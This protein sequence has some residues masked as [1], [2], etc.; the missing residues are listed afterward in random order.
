MNRSSTR[1]APTLIVG[2][3]GSGVEIAQRVKNMML[4]GTERAGTDVPAHFL[5]IDLDAHSGGK[6]L[7]SDEFLYV[8]PA[9]VIDKLKHGDPQTLGWLPAMSPIRQ[10]H[11]QASGAA[12]HRGIGHL[13]SAVSSF[14]IESAL[15][16]A[17]SRLPSDIAR[18]FVIA[19]LAGGTGS[20][21]LFDVAAAL[22]RI[23]FPGAIDTVLLLPEVF[24]AVSFQ[25]RM[26][27]IA[28]GTL[29]ELAAL[30]SKYLTLP[31]IVPPAAP[32]H[33]VYLQ[34]P[35]GGRMA[36]PDATYEA[37]AAMLEAMSRTPVSRH[38]TALQAN[39]H[40]SAGEPSTSVFSTAAK[41]GLRLLRYRELADAFAGVFLHNLSAG[42]H[43]LFNDDVPD[44]PAVE[45][46]QRIEQ[47][48][49]SVQVDDFTRS[50][51]RQAEER[52]EQAAA[53]P[54]TF[55]KFRAELS[56]FFGRDAVHES[57]WLTSA[58]P[59]AAKMVRE[60]LR[61]LQY[62]LPPVP[63]KLERVL[64]ETP[65]LLSRHLTPPTTWQLLND[66]SLDGGSIWKQLTLRTRIRTL[67]NGLLP[68]IGKRAE[69][70]LR[71]LIV[72]TALD[73]L[74]EMEEE[75]RRYW[76]RLNDLDILWRESHSV[77]ADAERILRVALAGLGWPARDAFK[78]RFLSQFQTFY[79]RYTTTR[80]RTDLDAWMATTR[81]LFEETFATPYVDPAILYSD[82]DV[83]AAVR[84]LDSGVFVPGRTEARAART[85]VTI[86][87]PG[88]LHD[89]DEFLR[90]LAGKAQSLLQAN[91]V[92]EMI[93][94][95]D[96]PEILLLLESHFYGPAAIRG[97][98]EYQTEYEHQPDRTAYHFD[99]TWPAL[100]QGFIDSLPADSAAGPR[101]P[102]FPRKFDIGL[103]VP[104]HEEFEIVQSHWPV[105][106]N[107]IVAG[108]TFLELDMSAAGV[109]CVATILREMGPS[110][111]ASRTEKLLNFADVSLLVLL[112][113]GGSL[114]DDVELSD[115]VIADEVSEFNAASKA[116][117][118]DD[119]SF[120]F[121]YSGFHFPAPYSLIDA[122]AHWPHVAKDD[123]LQWKDLMKGR[124]PALGDGR[125]R[126][127]VEHVASGDT[128]AAA[129]AFR[130]ELLGID[131]KFAALEMEGAGV[132]RA[133]V[134]RQPT[135]PF[136]IIRGISD[137]CDER[138]KTL[139]QAGKGAW[140]SLAVHSACD[141]LA[142]LLRLP[143]VR[144]AVKI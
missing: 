137:Y 6:S 38:H 98:R 117:P 25:A 102:A 82:D 32:F 24:S 75:E 67:K 90:D 111:A 9:S 26:L 11:L 121:R 97:I 59:A 134:T 132:A 128:V 14:R 115:I 46:A 101:R 87:V 129:E 16:R 106:G 71:Q 109:T 123:H 74:K 79:E 138:K 37:V 143:A 130:V 10:S 49:M 50:V 22:H 60:A 48:V 44:A 53:N 56:V 73:V 43:G 65:A 23:G 96:E 78:S 40:E 47:L 42:G 119:G 95:G 28:Y 108:T 17:V 93:D 19:S 113:I 36:A 114:N 92:T 100:L 66:D 68:E 99:R 84:R 20:G 124:A 144:S 77:D 18:A 131:R 2:I 118:A 8:D 120:R 51:T 27:P 76:A 135:V 107:E 89:S 21:M 62:Q 103:V 125:P 86:A 112:G 105:K 110:V 94:G 127:H 80:D 61:P 63:R 122:V 141:A 1:Y 33:R 139:D 116:V 31:G 88:D 15:R 136:L 52:F 83:S 39:A 126:M 3:G 55:P 70:L 72:V 69:A 30:Q 4:G 12:Q 5:G 91:V 34:G 133:A 104:L 140:R 7:A 81:G 142:R 29:I 64:G 41:A 85:R 35:W 58:R 54:A 45:I 57:F 13:A